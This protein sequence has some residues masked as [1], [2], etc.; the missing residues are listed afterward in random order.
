MAAPEPFAYPLEQVAELTGVSYS[1]LDRGCR[2][3]SIRYAQLGRA[4]V[5]TPE[6]IQQMLADHTV[7]SPAPTN[8][9]DEARDRAVQQ[10][11]DALR[12]HAAR[13]RAA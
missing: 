13:R 12:A 5:M 8:E 9:V 4:R 11:R 1:F 7:G 2:T 3:G 6:Q 10:R